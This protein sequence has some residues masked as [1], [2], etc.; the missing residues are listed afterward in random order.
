M[1]KVVSSPEKAVADIADGSS[2]AIAGFGLA[3]RFP[4]SL[5]EAL[6]KTGAKNLTLVCNSVGQ[7]GQA[8]AHLVAN[9]QASNLIAAF[10]SRPGA[11][12][13]VEEQ[14]AAGQLGMELVPQGTLVERLRA[15][16]AGLAGF[17]TP[18]GVGTD[19][20][21]GK[22][23]RYFD[24]KPYIFEHALHVDYALVRA[25]RADRM[26]N[27][28]FRGGSQ[29]FNPSFAKAARVTIAEADE[30]VDVGELPPSHIGLPGLF[31]SRVVK[32]TVQLNQDELIAGRARRRPA[33]VPRTYYGKP[34]LTREEIAER[35]A[36]LLPEGSYVNLGAGIPTL[37]SNYIGDRDI[38]MHAENG[39]LGYGE[40]V[41]GSA[42]DPDYYNASGQF[43]AIRPGASFFDSV[44]SFEIA[45][46]GKLTAVMLGAYQVDQD[47]NLA[48]WTTPDM[49]GGGIGGAMDL[50]SGRSPVIVLMEHC[51][52]HANTPKLIRKCTYPLTGVG[53]VDTVVTD[54]ALLR[55]RNGT[56]ALEEVAPGFSVNEV[57][58]LTDMD[59]KVAAEVG[60]MKAEGARPERVLSK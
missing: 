31:V 37:V 8:L 6:V 52:S 41:E 3:Q 27:L 47:G 39:I 20:A 21:N 5:L 17:Y 9:R 30:I 26:G 40:V 19:I 25:M 11:R 7:A 22:E 42:I 23:L 46:G 54:L 44:T 18:T 13:T 55:R 38:M 1:D 43:V 33:D 36:R 10:S 35:A 32:A 24:G 14:I 16:G 29:N 48:N 59:V 57:L 50:V 15:G 34:A 58:E 60:T 2:I 12:W 45:R 4:T 49:V 28:E 51:E 56:F 53:C